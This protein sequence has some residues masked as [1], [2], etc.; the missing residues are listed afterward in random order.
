MDFIE[1]NDS[2]IAKKRREEKADGVSLGTFARDSACANRSSVH[3]RAVAQGGARG[4]GDEPIRTVQVPDHLA[5]AFAKAEAAVSGY[6]GERRHDPAHGTIEVLNDRYV[7]VRAASLS[8][9]FFSFVRD[10]YGPERAAEADLF[11]RNLLFDLAHAIGRSD[12]R[13]FHERMHLVDPHERLAAGPVHFAHTGWALVDIL[14]GSRPRPDDDFYL[15]YDHPYSFEADAWLASG[16]H[17]DFPVC[18]MNAGYSSGWCE[19]SYGVR[20]VACE[21]LC[22]ARGDEACRFIMGH[23]DRIEGYLE[24]YGRDDPRLARPGAYEIPD[25][26]ARKRMEDELRRARDELE[27]RVRERTTELERANELLRREMAARE[28]AELELLQTARME[29]I[30]RLAGGIAHD[31]NNLMGVVIG[32]TSLVER[33]LA[34]DDPLHRHVIEIRR[35]AEEAAQLTQ[36]LLAF[37]RARVLNEE[38]VELNGIVRETV[39]TLGTL[40]GER[41][42][43]VLALEEPDARGALTVRADRGQLR[44]VIMNLAVNGRDA[45]PD[46][47]RL[48]VAT[49]RAAGTSLPPGDWIRLEVADT[50]TGMDPETLKRIFDPFF[51][52]KQPGLGTGL[53]LS[54][55]KR[56]VDHCGGR[57]EV[58][59]APGAGTSFRVLL[60]AAPPVAP[61]PTATT[62]EGAASGRGKT[63]LVVEDQQAVREMVVDV[64][65]EQGYAVL[66]AAD[67]DLALAAAAGNEGRIDLLLTDMIMPRMNGREL[68]ER[69]LALRPGLAVL[70][71]SGYADDEQLRGAG[72]GRLLA[73]PFGAEDLLRRVEES[74][75]GT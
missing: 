20:L 38:P 73:K 13:T 25:L 49:A 9:E 6:F 26:F 12:A 24:L 1:W 60:P 68:A 10:M 3:D 61:R 15:I 57:I 31:F 28:Q 2:S 17:S 64:L 40:L 36:Q 33:K 39:G 69:L 67:P 75:R 53:G 74:I 18:M 21:M 54:T 47:G 41:V 32:R 5:A 65:A 27:V 52:T 16:T 45:M 59:S 19:Q 70:F 34:A 35:T 62:G 48:T 7:L 72:A 46:G 8:V 50:G 51:T 42:E 44:Q 58:D 22:R 29:T 56:I 55:A 43:V 30:G 11:A 4:R 63:V 23:P 37:S 66:S 71:M 14:P